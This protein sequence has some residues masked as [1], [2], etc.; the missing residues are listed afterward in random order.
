M[1]ELK[2]IF[3]DLN[4][5]ILLRKCLHGK[6]QNLNELVNAVIWTKSPKTVFVRLKTL[7]FGVAEAVASFNKGAI[8]KFRIFEKLYYTKMAIDIERIRNADKGLEEITKK[9]QKTVQAAKIKLEVNL[10]EA[11]EEAGSSYDSG[12]Y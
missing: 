9:A 5:P 6:T 12:A 4:N 1:L 11:D 7:R 3:R 8:T 10:Q 2:L